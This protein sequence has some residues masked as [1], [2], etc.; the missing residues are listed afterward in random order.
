M[1]MLLHLNVALRHVYGFQ[2]V[3]RF[4]ASGVRAAFQPSCWIA[5]TATPDD[6][7]ES[8][9]EIR[10]GRF[11]LLPEL[12]RSSVLALDYLTTSG[13]QLYNF[14]ITQLEGALP[15]QLT[16]SPKHRGYGEK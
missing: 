2:C 9:R 4:S 1:R 13:R 5:S 8:S 15:A 7:C 3:D 6:I 16:S 11:N 12:L 10:L 14:D